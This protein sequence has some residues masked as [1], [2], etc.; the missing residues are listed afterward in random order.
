MTPRVVWL[1]CLTMLV[2][3]G[4]V[5]RVHD[6]DTYFLYALGLANEQAIRELGV[7]APEL[8]D[9]LGAEARDSA[10]AWLK[11][12]TFELRA[13]ADDG[14][15]RWLGYSIRGAD[16]LGAFLVRS[17]LAVRCSRPPC[18]TLH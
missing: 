1:L 18:P 13:C 4:H 2:L 12:G 16:T 8:R 14:F 11:R 9:S 7:N 6:G 10:E 3:P 15:G 17:H 5:K